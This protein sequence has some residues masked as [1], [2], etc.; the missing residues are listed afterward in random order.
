ML[1]Q[2]KS[3][4]AA[5]YRTAE[6]LKDAMIEIGMACDGGKDSLSMAATAA[7]EVVM[8]P[9]NLVI[10]A[11]AP[12][13]DITKIVTPDIKGPGN[14]LLHVDL[15]EVCDLVWQPYMWLT[16][17]RSTLGMK[18]QD[19]QDF[20]ADSV[21]RFI[22]GKRRTGGSALAQ[23]HGQVGD[24]SP[25]VSMATVKAAF[26]ATQS[27]VNSGQLL[28]GHDISDGGL[29][30]TLLE[31]SFAGTAGISVDVSAHSATVAEALFAEEPGFVLEVA[32]ADHD[33]V[34][35]AYNDAGVACTLLG[36]T[37]EAMSAR[38]SVDGSVEIAGTVAELRDVWEE[39][40]FALERLQA[41]PEMVDAEAAGLRFRVPP[42]WRM[43]YVPDW[44]PPNDVR[45][46]V[47]IV[48]EEG[49]NGDREMAAAVYAGG[50]L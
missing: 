12:C 7:G 23:A 35:S 22:Q 14:F 20:L 21:R 24:T 45:P 6:A 13:T 27:L 5:M 48:R 44:S 50:A 32:E 1:L 29:A 3:E 46:K 30:V 15:A 34:M 33:S 26:A 28:S 11:Y 36:A 19:V 43:T 16:R 25:D 39:T 47:A 31:M 41:A 17:T 2:L 4:G 10:S 38:I 18:N 42:K 9:G 40:A 8:A 49:S 37:T